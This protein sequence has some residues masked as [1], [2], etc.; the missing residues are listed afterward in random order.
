MLNEEA[1]IKNQT[2]LLPLLISVICLA[3]GYFVILPKI[4][5]L[6]LIN[7]QIEAKNQNITEV[8]NKITNLNL[9][10][11]EFTNN[12][13]TLEAVNLALADSSQLPEIIEQI[14][15][16]TQKSG[17]SLKSIKPDSK[18]INNELL[19]NLSLQGDFGSLITFT[20]NIEKNLRPI[21]LK[22]VSMSMST[23]GTFDANVGLGIL[24]LD[25]NKTIKA[26][27]TVSGGVNE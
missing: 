22:S 12:S 1:K 5:E 3:I 6:K 24:T 26:N 23:D 13:G 17:M 9:L 27:N 8:Q 20:Q 7:I 15:S 14:T 18:Q 16:I 10:K 25:D 4:E 19:V 2:Q 11:N 21:T